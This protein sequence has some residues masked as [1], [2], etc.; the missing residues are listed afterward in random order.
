M[1]QIFNP[2][3]RP[4]APLFPEE[5]VYCT[6]DDVANFLQ[7]PLPEPIAL[8]ADSSDNANNNQNINLPISG[9]NYRRWKIDEGINITV[10]DDNDALGKTYTVLTAESGG[11]GNVNIVVAS[12][13]NP[14]ETYTTS[15]NAYIQ[16]ESAFTNSKERGLTKS[17]VE[18]LIRKKQDYIDTVCRMSWRPRI[19]ADEYLNFTTFKPY[20]R[21]YYTDYVGAVYLRNSSVQRVLRLSI[22]QGD[23]YRE[24]AS[25]IVQITVDSNKI[26][27]TSEIYLCPGVAHF[28]T[29]ERGTNATS[30]DGNFGNKTT[31][32]NI[33]NLI[34]KDAATGRGDIPIGSLTENSKQLNVDDEFLATANSDEGDGVILI[35]SMRST[36]EGENSTF[37]FSNPEAFSTALHHDTNSKVTDISSIG[38][39]VFSVEDNNNFLEKHGLVYYTKGGVTYVAL[40]KKGTA[41][42]INV[43][44][45]ITT[46]FKAN[47][48]VDDVVKQDRLKTDVIDED[49]QKDWWSMEDNGAIMFNNQYPFYEN[50][51]IKVSYIYGERYLDK[52]IKEACIKLVAIDILLSDD[53]TVLFPEGTNNI[54][55][56]AK[57]QKLDEE[58]KRMLIPYQ[59][60]I[61]VA[62]MGG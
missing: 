12:K 10:Y 28:A 48:A 47:L 4:N 54:D 60:T 1:P 34:N 18:D 61:I 35:S 42:T 43:I 46:G 29:L 53:Y 36:E 17:H 27:N 59:E 21:R 40:C 24:L 13:S 8:S 6:T 39:N 2:G 37:A 30:W 56:N 7:L 62:G 14:N 49:R 3:H 23:K 45:E 25:S 55:L 57:V 20:R 26:G 38:S 33:A 15:A 52:T 19:V 50:H 44:Q 22:W 51:S 11:S 31:A 32:Q 16:I 41:N 9:A 5:L 58:V